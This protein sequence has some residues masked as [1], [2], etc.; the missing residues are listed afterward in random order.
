[1][2]SGGTKNDRRLEEHTVEVSNLFYDIF[3]FNL[4]EL[5]INGIGYFVER[6]LA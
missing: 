2:A 4:A 3:C 6:Y 5:K 1:M